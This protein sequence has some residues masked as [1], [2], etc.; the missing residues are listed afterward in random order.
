MASSR[1]RQVG[2][3]WWHPQAPFQPV[4]GQLTRQTA[5]WNSTRHSLS[6]LLGANLLRSWDPRDLPELREACRPLGSL[7]PSFASSPPYPLR[8]SRLRTSSLSSGPRLV[9]GSLRSKPLFTLCPLLY[10][11]LVPLRA[12]WLLL[13]VLESPFS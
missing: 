7:A 4:G 6:E 10:M 2:Q 8:V 12:L 3:S 13:W 5:R 9:I 11:T 1:Q